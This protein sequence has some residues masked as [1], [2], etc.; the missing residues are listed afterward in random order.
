MLAL[1]AL[2]DISFKLCYKYF[3]HLQGKW[4]YIFLLRIKPSFVQICEECY[5]VLM[6]FF[7]VDSLPLTSTVFQKV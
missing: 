4:S 7:N 3:K 1:S 6:F 5:T 2:V